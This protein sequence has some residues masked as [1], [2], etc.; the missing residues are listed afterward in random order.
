MTGLALWLFGA[1]IGAAVGLTVGLL[2]AA[3][4]VEKRREK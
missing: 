2:L 3:W 1:I 4:Y